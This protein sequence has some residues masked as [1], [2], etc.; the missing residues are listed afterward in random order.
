MKKCCF[1]IPYFGKLPNYFQLFLKSCGFN[2]DFD[3]MVFTD[4]HRDFVYPQ[5]VKRILMTFEELRNLFKK[6]FDFMIS[7]DNP[8]KL[9]DY[10]PSY[11]YVFEEYLRE[12]R[13]WGHCDI[14]LIFGKISNFVTN[15][16]LDGFDKIF[17]LGHLIL[18]KNEHENNRIFMSLYNGRLLY[19]DVFMSPQICIFDEEFK[20]SNN[21]NRIFINAGKK[22]FQN[23]YSLNIYIFD[24]RFRRIRFVGTN[25][26]YENAYELEDYKDCIYLWNKGHIERYYKYNESVRKEEFLYLHLQKRKMFYSDKVSGSDVFQIIPN[27]FCKMNDEVVITYENFEKCHCHTICLHKMDLFISRYKKKLKRA[28]IKVMNIINNKSL[29]FLI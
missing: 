20:D 4:D 22:V 2:P 18:Y 19:R 9:C 21:I 23:D 10:K 7:L 27:K 6:K 24:N 15:E 28:K 1:I 16:L 29:K 13:Y 5:N 8:Y 12:Y 25:K 14:D 11:G 17:C 26:G 3:W